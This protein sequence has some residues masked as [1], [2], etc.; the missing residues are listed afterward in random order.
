MNALK[1]LGYPF[2][3]IW[4][5]LN[6]TQGDRVAKLLQDITKKALPI[7]EVIAALTPTRVDDEIIALFKL[8]A[9]PNLD[10][11]LQI[12]IEQRGV[13]LLEV[14]V[15]QLQKHFP[16]VPI[17]MLKAAIEMAVVKF[18]VESQGVAI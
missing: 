3:K 4:N 14:A 1:I 9:L 15:S 2:I 17:F 11:W 18:K 13:V 5:F 10:K 7:V 6:G 12:P 16:N 8:Y